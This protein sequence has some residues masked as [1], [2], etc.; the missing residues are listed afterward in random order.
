MKVYFI[1]FYTVHTCARRD[2]VIGVCH[3]YI[4]VGM[5]VIQK[6]LNG[7]LAVNSPFQ[8]L[9]EHSLLNL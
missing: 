2:Y 5:Y 4:N 9:A 1:N 6:K 7:I 3:V 8:T